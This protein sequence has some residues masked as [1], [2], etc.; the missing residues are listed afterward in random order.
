[1]Y[2]GG[3]RRGQGGQGRPSYDC[4]LVAAVGWPSLSALPSPLSAVVHL[5]HLHRRTLQL[6]PLFGEERA[7]LPEHAPC[8]LVGDASLPLN[9]FRGDAAT[10]GTHEVHRVE[11]SLE[12]SS[13]LLEDGSGQRVNVVAA[14]V[15]GID[16][17]AS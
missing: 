2:H 17:A 9:L 10:S 8:G 3:K 16:G 5:V 12:R 11:P 6:H 14:M 7:N 1:M 15:T 4:D 13:G